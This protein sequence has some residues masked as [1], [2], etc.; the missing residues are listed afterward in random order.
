MRVIHRL[1]STVL[2]LMLDAKLSLKKVSNPSSRAL[3]QIFSVVLL[4]LACC[5]S[6]IRPSFYFLEKLSKVDLA[7]QLG[8]Q[9]GK[10]LGNH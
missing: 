1:S 5:L 4:A 9:F 7:K 10:A 3:V 2:H 8:Q 6:M